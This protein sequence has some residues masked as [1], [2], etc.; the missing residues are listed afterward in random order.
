MVHLDS[1]EDV[2]M[3]VEMAVRQIAIDLP[4]AAY[5]AAE[6]FCF[7][8]WER[9]FINACPLAPN[10]VYAQTFLAELELSQFYCSIEHY[11][12]FPIKSNSKLTAAVAR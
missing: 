8:F 3:A 2:E 4:N 9:Y 6:I 12:G 10:K 1:S 5:N 7:Q 11:D